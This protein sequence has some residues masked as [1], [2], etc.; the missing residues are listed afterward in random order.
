MFLTSPFVSVLTEKR[1][2]MCVYMIKDDKFFQNKNKVKCDVS[3]DFIFNTF[4]V[5]YSE[6]GL[7]KAEINS[8]LHY[9]IEFQLKFKDDE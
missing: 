9:N 7:I 1:E 8:F 3:T 5:P 6:R 2:T 4:N